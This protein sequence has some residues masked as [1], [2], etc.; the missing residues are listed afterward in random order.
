VVYTIGVVLPACQVKEGAPPLPLLLRAGSEALG[1]PVPLSNLPHSVL[2]AA[3]VFQQPES[4]TQALPEVAARMSQASS[5]AAADD[6]A[7]VQRIGIERQGRRQAALDAG[8]PVDEEQVL[9]VK[10]DLP[11]AEWTAW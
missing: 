2:A 3:R 7:A 10:T 11:C 8:Q 4:Y 5:A 1:T 6:Y 9:P